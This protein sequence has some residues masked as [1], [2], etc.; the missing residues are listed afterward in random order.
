MDGYYYLVNKHKVKLLSWCESRHKFL[1]ELENG[2]AQYVAENLLTKTD[3]KV[4]EE[5]PKTK[6]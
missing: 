6:Y 4:P 1:V 5:E 3:E 2:T